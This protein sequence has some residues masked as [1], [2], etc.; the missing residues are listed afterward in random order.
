MQLLVQTPG[1]QTLCLCFP[2]KEVDVSS[3]K[4]RIQDRC[5]IP[6][7]EQRLSSNSREL[8]DGQLVNEM[9]TIRLGLRLMGGKGGFG[10]LLRGA[11]AKAGAKKTTNFDD[12]RDLNGERIRHVKN[13]TKLAE[14]YA[15]EKERE[16]EEARERME[17]RQREVEAN[18]PHQF[19]STSF[20]MEL[21]EIH[22]NIEAS[23]EEVL[24]QQQQKKKVAV[25]PVEEPPAKKL[26]KS[27]LLWTEF[28]DL[29]EQPEQTKE[30][31]EKEKEEKEAAER[32]KLE[33]TPIDLSQHN[34]VEELEA[35]GGERL[36]KE[37]QRLGL[38]CGGTV[39][40]R[41]QRL[42][43]I[44]GKDKKDCDPKL[45]AKKRK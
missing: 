24:K 12:C 11:G 19:D 15:K 23:V 30:E 8:H 9:W 31:I 4:S 21:R 35:L 32:K 29:D 17:K 3:L 44:K 5:G 34:S 45:L 18:P 14:W 13:E 43:S 41:A 39:Q 20:I 42:L 27:H 26:K 38:L 22:H 37:L 16:E 40:Q 6:R 2:Q 25:P 33:E 7:E 10:A 1:G 28:D 36:K